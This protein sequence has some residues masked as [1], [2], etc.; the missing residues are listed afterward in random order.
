MSASSISEA[1][2]LR[3]KF[4]DIIYGSGNWEKHYRTQFKARRGV[5]LHAVNLG[6]SLKDCRVAFLN[7]AN[8]GSVLW[9][10]GTGGRELRPVEK[11]KR[12]EADYKSCTAKAVQS[13]PAAGADEI[14]QRVG[15]IRGQVAAVHFPGRD[16][17]TDRDVLLAV[18]GRMTEVGCDR[19]NLSVRD[20]S[21]RAGVS[22]R[23]AKESLKRL[24]RAGWLGRTR[25]TVRGQADWFQFK[26]VALLPHM[27]PK[28][29]PGEVIWGK[30]ATP[31][32]PAH[33]CWLHL[34]KAAGTVWSCLTDQP[35]GVRQLAR[36]GGVDPSTASRQLPK[37]AEH[38]LADH[39]DQGWIAGPCTPVDVMLN[40][41]W[42]G[43]GSRTAKRLK[44]V[45]IDRVAYALMRG[46]ITLAQAK[47]DHP[48]LAS[49]IDSRFG[50][51]EIA[52]EPLMVA[53]V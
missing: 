32:D 3:D 6:W 42:L 4:A 2:P 18:L 1:K 49:E 36:A 30:N 15:V 50:G 13:P 24:V 33:E 11:V 28:D 10:Q 27:S 37:L 39:V 16:G 14:R 29:S 20:A 35:Q 34:G 46:E 45:A 21:L 7:P 9:T 53:V 12:L 43:N 48:G 23:T 19:V 47:A 51:L 8:P 44:D 22:V 31:L 38:K 26:G 25:N 17:R 52:D 5:M 40:M 41:G